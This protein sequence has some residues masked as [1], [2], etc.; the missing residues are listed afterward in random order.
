MLFKEESRGF[1]VGIITAVSRL[2]A[3]VSALIFPIL[4]NVYPAASLLMGGAAVLIFGLIYS[5]KNAPK[6]H[7]KNPS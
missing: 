6:D 1:W 3:L 7:L 4:L 5:L 2:G